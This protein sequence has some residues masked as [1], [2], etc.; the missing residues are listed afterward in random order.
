MI[1]YCTN[2]HPGESWT[3][4]FLNLQAH[5]P[6]VKSAVSPDKPF[7]IGLRLSC[8]AAS[9]I[10]SDTGAFRAFTEWMQLTKTYIPTINGFPYGLFHSKRIKEN[11]YLPDWRQPERVDYTKLLASLLDCWLPSDLQGSIST[12]PIGFKGCISE[13]DFGIVKKNLTSVLE[14]L[15][16]LYLKSGKKILL[17][18][19]PEPGCLLETVDEILVF[20]ERMEF[21]DEHRDHIGVCLDCC[22]LAVEFEEPD[23][24]IARL[25]E[26][27]IAIAKVQ[28][29]SAPRFVDPLRA[30]LERLCEPNYLHQVVIRSVEGKLLRY[31]DLPEALQLHPFS[32]GEEWRVHYHLPVFLKNTLWGNTTQQFIM[33]LLPLLDSETLLEIETYTWDV[34]P[35]ELRSDSVTDSIIQEIKWLK[36]EIK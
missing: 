23:A 3:D 29:S 17:A 35:A 32:R 31:V 13:I 18:L 34:L 24:A 15:S 25:G 5:I 28:I 19:E 4:T 14:Y 20:F 22:H 12:V 9:E 27:G 1:T 33:E 8:Q 6:P 11:V 7:P 36:T 26:A 30:D 21:S 2:I 10:K 16:Q